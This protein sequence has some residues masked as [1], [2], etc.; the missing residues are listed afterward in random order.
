MDWN[1][2]VA[3]ISS[4]VVFRPLRPDIPH[5]FLIFIFGAS[6]LFGSYIC[7]SHFW[8]GNAT[9]VG[10]YCG[11]A[12]RE[13]WSAGTTGIKVKWTGDVAVGF[14][15][16]TGSC[17]RGREERSASWRCRTS[18]ISLFPQSLLIS[19]LLLIFL[20]FFLDFS[21][22]GLQAKTFGAEHW[23]DRVPTST[24]S[25]RI[26]FSIGSSVSAATPYRSPYPAFLY[27][28]H[29][30]HFLSLSAHISP[31][32]HLL[33]VDGRVSEIRP[34]QPWAAWINPCRLM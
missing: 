5:R 18:G 16:N 28:K 12:G 4:A 3:L 14:L 6:I 25:A 8:L 2:Q 32:V 22:N 11:R 17:E 10:S 27:R 34:M 19:G 33:L 23:I 9:R 7:A 1:E 24:A 30:F 31:V 29:S 20:F 13:E 21:P 15:H 26:S